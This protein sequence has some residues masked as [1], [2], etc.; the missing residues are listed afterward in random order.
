MARSIVPAAD[1]RPSEFE[2]FA[3]QM[4]GVPGINAVKVGFKVGLGLG[5]GNA[6]SIAYE[7]GL[8]V[9]YDHQKAGTDTPHT[10]DDFSET[11]QSAHVDAAIL[12]PRHDNT[13]VAYITA[14]LRRNIRVLLGS[15][16]THEQPTD[17]ELKRHEERIMLGTRFGVH[18]FVVPGN[19]PERIA[20]YRDLLDSEL[21]QD[22][23]AMWAPGIGAQGGDVATAARMASPDFHAFVGRDI[24]EAEQPRVAA[25]KY[26]QQI[27]AV[28]NG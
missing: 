6:T 15:E 9:V 2:N 28:A 11:M 13:Q 12:Y 7:Y 3:Q 22:N 1:V 17:E 10:A 8:A 16:M 19:K 21:G 25:I 5:L 27:L 26:G 14:L 18:D 23:Y 24:F 4:S 20:A